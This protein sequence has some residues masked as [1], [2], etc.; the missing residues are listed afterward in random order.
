MA[1]VLFGRRL[2]IVARSVGESYQ[3]FRKGLSD[4][5]STIQVDEEDSAQTEPYSANLPDYSDSY[6]D[7]EA[8]DF[9]PPKFE[10]ANKEKPEN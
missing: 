9:S 5:Q 3:Q 2:P 10:D 8:P 4:L 6:D 1:V 7:E